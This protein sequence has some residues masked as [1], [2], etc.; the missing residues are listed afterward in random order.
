MPVGAVISYQPVYNN[1]IKSA[2]ISL[3]SNWQTIIEAGG[4]NVADASL[5]TN[6]ATQITRVTTRPFSR[7]GEGTT[8]LIKLR[9]DA[10]LASPTSP[11]IQLFGK[12]TTDDYDCVVNRA[13]S[14]LSTIGMDTVNDILNPAG[15]FKSTLINYTTLAYDCG[16]FDDFLLGIARALSGTGT[17]N[18]ATILARI[19]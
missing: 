12:T 8:I 1:P 9:Y 7:K 18:N 17:V 6:P 16:G 3:T 10:G 2:P 14:A 13:G 4:V 5:I 11:I 19:V 15:T